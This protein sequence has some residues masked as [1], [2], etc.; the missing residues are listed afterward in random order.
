MKATVIALLL[1]CAFVLHAMAAAPQAPLTYEQMLERWDRATAAGETR[2]LPEYS[3]HL[4]DIYETDAFSAGLRDGL[5]IRF[6]ARSEQIFGDLTPFVMIGAVCLGHFWSRLYLLPLLQPLFATP[7]ADA[8]RR[9]PTEPPNNSKLYGVGGWLLVL[10]IWLTFVAPLF[11]FASLSERASSDFQWVWGVSLVIFTLVTGIL[12]WTGRWIGWRVATI[13]FWTI[14]GMAWLAVI[15]HG[16]AEQMGQAI[17]TSILSGIWLR[18]LK[19]STRVKNTYLTLQP[20]SPFF[21]SRPANNTEPADARKAVIP[22]LWR[23]VLICIAV[24]TGLSTILGLLLIPFF[25]FVGSTDLGSEIT[26]LLFS[27]LFNCAIAFLCIRSLRKRRT[28]DQDIIPAP[29]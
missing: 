4:N 21:Y 1:V 13:Y 9:P 11:S 27:T 18:Y 6:Y 25:F 22:T 5:W 14:A 20:T 16:S 7:S 10:C 28:Q 12:L 17:V 8:E 23:M 15:M 3:R 19:T 26:K 29:K 2:T 24:F